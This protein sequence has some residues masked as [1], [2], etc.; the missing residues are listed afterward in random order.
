[1]KSIYLDRSRIPVNNYLMKK[2]VLF[3]VILA[4]AGFGIYANETEMDIGTAN[5]QR[6]APR[7]SRFNISAG[8][9]YTT[10]PKLWGGH[11]DFGFGL[12]RKNFYVEN[13]F[14]LRAGGLIGSDINTTVF[15]L[16]DKLVFGRK[17]AYEDGGVY[18]YIEGG[19]GT[20]GNSERGFFDDSLAYSFG[21]G[22]GF[23]MGDIDYGA[24]YIDGGYLG[25]KILDKFP[26]SGFVVQTGWRIL[27]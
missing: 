9:T 11:F 15:T 10:N 19:A 25:Q 8:M 7:T 12:S 3:L 24:F 17:S 27:L 26:I 23:V 5:S 20:Y 22:G 21:F 2:I 18:I 14:V 4:F 13:H 16:S 6:E 1:M